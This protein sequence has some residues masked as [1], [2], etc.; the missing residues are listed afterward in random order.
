MAKIADVAKAKP[1]EQFTS[2]A[3]LINEELLE[4]CHHEMDPNKASGIDRVMKE[5]Y[6]ESLSN[7]LQDL[8]VQMKQHSYHPQ[9]VKRVY[10]PKTGTKEL[11]PLGIPAY[12]DK[13][14][15]AA[16]SKILNAIYEADF[17][18]CSFGFRPNRGCHDALKV[19]NHIIEKSKINYIVDADIKGFFNHVDHQCLLK[20]IGHRIKDPNIHH[21]IIRLLKSGVMYKGEFSDTTEGTPQGGLCKA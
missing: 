8:V 16:L 15:Q 10:I 9:P 7:K 11:R 14:V 6:G 12:E 20:F 19:L 5:K 3:H 13:L 21:L 18:E 2:L 1:K 17:M 4:I